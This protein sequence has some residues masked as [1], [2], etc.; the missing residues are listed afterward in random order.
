MSDNDTATAILRDEH[1]WILQVVDVLDQTLEPG[2]PLSAD[3]YDVIGRC[4]GFFRLYADACH[5]GK[6]EDLLFPELEELGVP[7][8]GGPIGV[9]LE[10]HRIGRAFVR[11]M[12]ESLPGARSGDAVA[13]TALLD[14]A[15]GY[16]GLIRA[17]IDKE[18]NVLFMM[19]DG[20]V[21]GDACRQLCARYDAVC[22]RRFEGK[23]RDDLEALAVELT[24]R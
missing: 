12:A 5:H 13:T 18:D 7:R 21:V 23:T 1:Q 9:M 11:A 14:A 19:A 3:A 17:H 22:S 20:I 8:E 15:H 4:T 6:E 2:P 10:E 16:I 24:M